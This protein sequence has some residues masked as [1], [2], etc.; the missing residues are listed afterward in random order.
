MK[1]DY[2]AT[3]KVEVVETIHGVELIDRYRWLED[4]SD[5]KVTAWDKAQNGFTDSYISKIPYRNKIKDRLLKFM[6]IDEMS[7]PE[8]VLNGERIL[9]YKKSADHEKWVL[10]TQKNENSELEELLNPNNWPQDET[11]H[12]NVSSRDGKYLVYGVSKGGNEDPVLKVMEIE[13]RKVLSDS[14]CGW[15]QYISD[16]M[17]DGSGFFYS[18]KPLKGD[19][20]EG[21]EFYWPAVY[22]HKL[23]TDKNEDKKLY[24]DDKVKENWYSVQVTEDGKYLKR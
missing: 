3:K 9:Q 22:Y 18:C 6:K 7:I 4:S 17:P 11:L 14:V 21:E 16:W 13:S 12:Y 8:K 23:G 5:P 15:M 19:V 20:P 10:Y 2:P 24:Y 1:F